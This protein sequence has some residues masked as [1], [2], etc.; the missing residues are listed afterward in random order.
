MSTNSISSF[1]YS[2]SWAAATASTI[3]ISHA[4]PKLFY[5]AAC[6]YTLY[7]IIQFDKALLE[8]QNREEIRKW[9]VTACF[10]TSVILTT[11][12]IHAVHWTAASIAYGELGLI[13]LKVGL[14]LLSTSFM[15]PRIRTIYLKGE[16]LY[17][18]REWKEIEPFLAADQQQFSTALSDR[19]IRFTTLLFPT[20]ARRYGR[21]VQAETYAL[22]P[23]S[24]CEQLWKQEFENFKTW[25]GIDAEG[26]L[27]Y[28]QSSCLHK[29]SSLTS[30]SQIRLV[31]EILQLQ[32]ILPQVDLPLHTGFREYVD[33]ERTSLRTSF[34]EKMKKFNEQ[35]EELKST[36]DKDGLQEFQ[37]VFCIFFSKIRLYL[38]KETASLIQFRLA[39]IEP[40]I[41]EFQKKVS[42]SRVGQAPFDDDD[43][44]ADF[45]LLS[46]PFVSYP[47]LV[48]TLKPKGETDV[49][50]LG[51]LYQLLNE[52][53]IGTMKSFIDRVMNGDQTPFLQEKATAYEQS[54]HYP[55]PDTVFEKL[56]AYLRPK[57]SF[58]QN[59]YE[60]LS[61]TF[62]T[63]T[64][65]LELLERTVYRVTILFITVAP[66]LQNPVLGL[67]G[68][69]L[70]A[71][72]QVSFFHWSV[73]SQLMYY[74]V[75]IH[76]AL[77]HPLLPQL[78]LAETR[79][80]TTFVKS[81]LLG[82]ASI[83]GYELLL[84]SMLLLAKRKYD[85]LPPLKVGALVQGFAIGRELF[86]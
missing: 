14:I 5:P 7:N 38:P 53:C 59:V 47:K 70:G 51:N 82:K 49:D 57:A 86:S 33:R 78:R 45:F 81:D 52:Y 21:H 28:L 13:V 3:I 9:M 23:E 25:H 67:C 48:Q 75:L 41:N 29:L 60:V 26:D 2:T 16:H 36:F 34:E 1:H 73:Y 54:Y 72:S 65:A 68:I 71:M 6:T 50:K 62:C 40:L 74:V 18:Q 79:E 69:A 17:Q 77:R 37:R 24:E 35:I 46:S 76:L 30:S 12:L 20:S 84:S 10:V 15:I 43:S 63:P 11:A 31:E 66:L 58:R 19:L 83:L 56:E 80:I 39:H 55:I 32:E 22:L 64:P 8:K 4:T 85:N 61:N 27:S 42:A 44:P